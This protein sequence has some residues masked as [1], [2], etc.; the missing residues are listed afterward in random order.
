MT[1]MKQPVWMP[2]IDKKPLNVQ[3]Q[4][5][6]YIN[7]Y[8]PVEKLPQDQMISHQQIISMS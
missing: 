3:D 5:V 7:T 8:I 4:Y 6:L 2:S 1:A